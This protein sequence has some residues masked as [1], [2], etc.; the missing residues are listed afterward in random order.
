MVPAGNDRKDVQCKTKICSTFFFEM[1]DASIMFKSDVGD[2]GFQ[3]RFF[4]HSNGR[5]EIKSTRS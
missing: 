2:T 1:L 3:M 5:H 4:L